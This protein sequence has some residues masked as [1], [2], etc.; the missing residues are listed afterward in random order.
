MSEKRHTFK[1]RQRIRQRRDFRRLRVAACSAADG[2]MVVYAA[3]NGL[4][5][6]RVAFIAG[7]RI[8]PAVQRNR[9]RRLLREAFRLEQ[10]RL[11]AGVDL[12]LIAR[13]RATDGLSEY[14]QGLV[15]LAR[16]AVAK[17][18]RRGT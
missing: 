15:R 3:R 9:V 8:G 6:A 7:K 5:H 13:H 12:L 16:R 14:R 17:L 10:H 1:R 2:R 4:P 11:P 18:E